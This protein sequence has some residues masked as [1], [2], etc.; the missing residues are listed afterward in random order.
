MIAHPLSGQ[1]PRQQNRDRYECHRQAVQQ[2]GFDPAAAA[3]A[4][5]AHVAD[6]YHRVLAD[7]LS[8]RDYSVN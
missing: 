5:P 7:C 4:P 2:S 3:V 6:A 1:T 8:A